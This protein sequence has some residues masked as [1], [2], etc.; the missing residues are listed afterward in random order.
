MRQLTFLPLPQGLDPVSVASISDNLPDAWRT[1]GPH[2]SRRPDANV[3]VVGG[4]TASIGLYAVAIARSLGVDVTYLDTAEERAEIARSFGAQAIVG[5]Y[6]RR[7]DPHD[8][9]VDASATSEGLHCA[10]R[11][12]AGDGVC[13]CVA[14]L[15]PET[16]LPLMEMYVRTVTFII[17]RVSARPAMDSVLELL[18]GGG[19]D[20][21]PVTTRVVP[22]DQAAE[23][24]TEPFT[25]LVFARE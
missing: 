14:T 24:Y 21:Q 5:A 8:I 20:P 9:T 4:G 1:V 6:P 16:P 13:T 11:S 7:V 15:V 19:L 10:V 3:L 17:G 2:L 22:W 18:Q 25:K 23:A 12:T